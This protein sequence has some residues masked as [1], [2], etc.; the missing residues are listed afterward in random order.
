MGVPQ[1]F[2]EGV[3]F[4]VNLFQQH[5][6]HKLDIEHYVRSKERTAA[7]AKYMPSTSL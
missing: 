1:L 4:L 7:A 2:L 3:H 6:E 5:Q